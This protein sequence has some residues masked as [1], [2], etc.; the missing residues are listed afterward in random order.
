MKK[1]AKKSVIFLLAAALVMIPFGATTLAE[2][3]FEAKEPTGAEMIYDTIV[4]RPIGIVATVLGAAM[5]VV[6]YPFSASGDNVDEAKIKLMDEPAKFTF[7][8]PLGEF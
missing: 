6:S 4:I 1:I 2:E 5:Y 7:K 8:R 3:Y